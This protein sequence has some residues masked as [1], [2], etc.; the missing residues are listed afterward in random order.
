MIALKMI[1][2]T[3]P[4][5]MTDPL[6]K[7]CYYI[8]G[9]GG[10][11][12]AVR[13]THEASSKHT[14]VF[15]SDIKGYY[16]SLR[17][18]VLMNIISTYVKHP[19]LLTLIEKALHRTES[20]GGLYYEYH[21]KG[22]PK[23][24]PLSPLLGAIA[25]L[26]LDQAM[27]RTQDIFYAR[28]MDDWVVLTHSKTALRKI[29]RKTH[30]ILQGLHLSLHPLKT[31]IGKIANGFNF[32]GYYMDTHR[33]LPSTETILRFHERALVLYEHPTEPLKRLRHTPK[34]DI[35]EYSAHE[36]PPN[37]HEFRSRLVA[38]LHRGGNSRHALKASRRIRGYLDQWTR[39]IRVG[40]VGNTQLISSTQVWM[41]EL[42]Q[43][44]LI[45]RPDLNA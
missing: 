17:F 35:S 1:S 14:Y 33:L 16:E 24:S 7:T 12:Q 43:I 41:P 42:Y 10:L 4:E 5:L 39:W 36:P 18:D 9:S 8:K 37:D 6:S 3:L 27:S 13:L 30:A 44:W 25:L 38:L 22:I 11:K 19:V 21:Q 2:L 20:F 40:L 23:G 45:Q 28:Y 34:R 26:P 32:L 15:R 31:Y 29:I